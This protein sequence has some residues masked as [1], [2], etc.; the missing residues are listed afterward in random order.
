MHLP[1]RIGGRVFGI[2]SVCYNQPHAFPEDEQRLFL[3]LAQRAA[4][5]IE[6]AQLYEQSQELAVVRERQRLARELH[7]A[8][9]QTLFSASLIA[10]VLPALWERDQ[11]KARDYLDQLRHLSRG[12]LAEMRTLLMELRP[13]ALIEANLG[14]LLRQ[15]T[16]AMAGKARLSVNVTVE[17]PRRLPPDVHV[18]LYRIAQEALN[19]VVKHSHANHVTVNL[20]RM[21][22]EDHDR[23]ILSVRDDGQGFDPSA[24]AADHLGLGIMQERAQTIGADLTVDTTSGQGTQITVVWPGVSDASP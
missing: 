8:V 11:Q 2:F 20:Y 4:L 12:A 6:N 5:A 23:I 17:E 7:D 13:T 10:E 16:D 14:D 3:A 18:A 15:L 9:T 24:V 1:I 19:N 22:A 21:P